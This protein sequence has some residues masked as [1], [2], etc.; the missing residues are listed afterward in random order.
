M[1]CDGWSSRA[2][3]LENRPLEGYHC[4]GCGEDREWQSLGPHEVVCGRCGNAEGLCHNE[5]EI[6]TV[7]YVKQ[8]HVA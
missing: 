7:E 6:S 4:R 1:Y 5:T 8:R 2:Y 3:S